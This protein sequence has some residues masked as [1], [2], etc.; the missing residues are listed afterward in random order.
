MASVSQ[1]KA[2]EAMRSICRQ[3]VPASKRRELW[4]SLARIFKDGTPDYMYIAAKVF[5][6]AHP[7]PSKVYSVSEL[8]SRIVITSIVEL[9]AEMQ[10][11][12]LGVAPYYV[13]ESCIHLLRQPDFAMSAAH[14]RVVCCLAQTLGLRYCPM[15]PNLAFILLEY[16]NEAETYAVVKSLYRSGGAGSSAALAAS[17]AAAAAGGGVAAGRGAQ[18]SGTSSGSLQMFFTTREQEYAFALAFLVRGLSAP[19]QPLYAQAARLTLPLC[20]ETRERAIPPFTWAYRAPD[21]R[22]S[23]NPGHVCC[24]VSWLLLRLAAARRRCALCGLVPR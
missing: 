16:L 12:F 19:T 17:P 24:V 7:L 11:P 6:S 14:D 8:K 3:Q 20:A 13:P 21:W 2:A 9:L 18:A 4:L 10:V 23:R 5:G 1:S 15:V 22:R